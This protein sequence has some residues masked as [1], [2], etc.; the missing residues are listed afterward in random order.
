DAAGDTL[1]HELPP[2]TVQALRELARRRGWSLHAL[3]LAA[4]DVLLARLARQDDI[5]VGTAVSG[6]GRPDMQRV[7]GMFVHPLVL[8]N[9][10]DPKQP[11]AAFADEVARHSLEALDNQAFPF[12]DL[13]DMVGDERHA[14]HTPLVDVMFTL[15]SA[16]E[17]GDGK[18]GLLI[19]VQVDTHS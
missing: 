15:Q 19:P 12:A 16:E 8:A 4:F 14:G 18:A 5:A 1:V 10:V 17:R 3:M 11:F 13:V 6:R 9:T 7:G 2:A